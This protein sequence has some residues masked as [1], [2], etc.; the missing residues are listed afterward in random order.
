MKENASMFTFQYRLKAVITSAS[1][2]G[3]GQRSQN[4]VEGILNVLLFILWVV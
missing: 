1:P 2:K 3:H 4:C